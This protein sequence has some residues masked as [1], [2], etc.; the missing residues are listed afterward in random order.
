MWAPF[1]A[2]KDIDLGKLDPEGTVARARA[3]RFIAKRMRRPDENDQ[4]ARN[5]VSKTITYAVLRAGDLKQVRGRFVVNDLVSWLR[6]KWP[7]RFADLS[8][9]LFQDGVSRLESQPA[10]LHATVVTLPSTLHACHELIAAQ[11]REIDSL[12]E[13]VADMRKEIGW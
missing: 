6:K 3:V 4:Q 5:R 13:Q 11:A 9:V 12:R 7:K 1:K 10:T 8:V 2:A